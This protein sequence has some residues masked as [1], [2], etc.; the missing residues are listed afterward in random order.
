MLARRMLF[1]RPPHAASL[2][3]LYVALLAI[4]AFSVFGF[5]V[6]LWPEDATSAPRMGA[7]HSAPASRSSEGGPHPA[8]DSRAPRS[9]S[10]WI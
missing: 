7:G 2:A 1:V 9:R 4:V 6:A 10:T 3:P 5:A 8:P